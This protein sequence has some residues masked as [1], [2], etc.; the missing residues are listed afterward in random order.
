[1]SLPTSEYATHLPTMDRVFVA[2]YCWKINDATQS[3]Q[4][5]LERSKNSCQFVFSNRMFQNGHFKWMTKITDRVKTNSASLLWPNSRSAFPC[6]CAPN[7]AC[8]SFFLPPTSVKRRSIVSRTFLF[9]CLFVWSHSRS[10][11]NFST[12]LFDTGPIW[13]IIFLHELK[14]WRPPLFSGSILRSRVRI[15]RTTSLLLS[16]NIWI[17]CCEKDEKK[18]KEA[19][20]G[21]HFK[22]CEGQLAFNIANVQK[23]NSFVTL[24]VGPS[25]MPP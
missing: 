18:Q 24:L 23:L 11:Y 9:L 21:P 25:P 22:I 1:M 14:I 7:V 4:C 5:Q 13:Q 16:I 20:I 3:M 2:S 15:S 19:R 17:V 10:V 8:Y 6:F 12:H